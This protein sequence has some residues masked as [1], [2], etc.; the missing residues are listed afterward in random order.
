MFMTHLSIAK[1]VYD[2]NKKSLEGGRNNKLMGIQGNGGLS[3]AQHPQAS[4]RLGTS[5]TC[6]GKCV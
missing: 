4:L 2:G 3:S 5:K 6:C 1:T